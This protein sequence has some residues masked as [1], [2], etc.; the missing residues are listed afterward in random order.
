MVQKNKYNKMLSGRLWLTGIAGLSFLCFTFTICQILYIKRNDM[1][2]AE[3][4]GILNMLLIVV[5]NIFTFYFS[6]NR[7]EIQKE[8]DIVEVQELSNKEES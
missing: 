3:V 2:A 7:N 5:S 8:K 1:T 6:K 4:T